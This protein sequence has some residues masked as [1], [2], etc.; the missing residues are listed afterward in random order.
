MCSLKYDRASALPACLPAQAQF[1]QSNKFNSPP[2]VIGGVRDRHCSRQRGP[3]LC[4]TTMTDHPASPPDPPPPSWEPPSLSC[5]P[6]QWDVGFCSSSTCVGYGVGISP[7]HGDGCDTW[8]FLEPPRS[9]KNMRWGVRGH[10]TS[11][12]LHCRIKRCTVSFFHTASGMSVDLICED[13]N[14]P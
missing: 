5:L 9:H 3:T 12:D 10:P 1:N 4:A 13:N 7:L 8:R 6:S 11:S 14:P 2:P